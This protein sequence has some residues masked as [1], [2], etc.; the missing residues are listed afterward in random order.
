[1]KR[2]EVPMSKLKFVSETVQAWGEL[3]VYVVAPDD[4]PPESEAF[5]MKRE[6]YSTQPHTIKRLPDGSGTIEL[7]W[8]WGHVA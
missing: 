6:N 1:M 4:M 7:F 5:V 3:A 2:A 8:S